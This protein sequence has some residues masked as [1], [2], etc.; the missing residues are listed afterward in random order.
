MLSLIDNTVDQYREPCLYYTF[1]ID[2]CQEVS[3]IV[4]ANDGC[5]SPFMRINIRWRIQKR[6]ITKMK[7]IA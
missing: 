7:D 5:Y 3:I 2:S 1:S 4:N 6:K